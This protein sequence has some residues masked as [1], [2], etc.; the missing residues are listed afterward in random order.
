MN[1]PTRRTLL[2]SIAG[3]AALSGC[4]ESTES[5]NDSGQ[6]EQASV[7]DQQLVITVS[8]SLDAEAISVVNPD[9][10]SFA[11]TDLSAGVTRVSF[12]IGTEYVPGEYRI[13]ATDGE[14]TVAETTT[15]IEPDLEI[16]EVGVGENHLDRM[17]E[18][19]QFPERQILVRIENG[20]T[21]PEA[22][23]GLLIQGDVPNPSDGSE[24]GSGIYDESDEFGEQ[25]RVT[26][27]PGTEE[28]IF[29]TNLPFANVDEECGD[30]Y[31]TPQAE[32]LLETEVSEGD[33]S[34]QLGIEY[35]PE[36]NGT[37]SVEFAG[38]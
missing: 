9:G 1:Q 11:E 4:S 21:G 20:G 10:E 19:L 3:A 36:G 38:E 32:V 12:D 27:Y 29:S 16:V 2:C 25:E 28:T 23:E 37:C 6:F 13:L 34:T 30:G 7:E 35:T 24:S 8:E 17:A 22:I 15:V 26:I 33:V 31:E 5:P 18:E 14:E